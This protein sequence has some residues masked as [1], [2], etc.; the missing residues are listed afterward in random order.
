MKPKHHYSLHLGQHLRAHGHLWNTLVLERKHTPSKLHGSTI[1]NTRSYEASMARAL[2]NEQLSNLESLPATTGLEGPACSVACR[3]IRGIE[4][5]MRLSKGLALAGGHWWAGYF[6]LVDTSMGDMVGR[7]LGHLHH[8][9]ECMTVLEMWRP[10]P[11]EGRLAPAGDLLMTDS[12]SLVDNLVY[13]VH[14]DELVVASSLL[15]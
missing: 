14:G 4:V 10:S 7:V 13:S 2:V 1:M 3:D 11:T 15:D 6:A 12:R 9:F 5:D 8:Q